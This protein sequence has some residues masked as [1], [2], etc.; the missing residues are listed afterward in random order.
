V[1][2]HPIA[3]NSATLFEDLA[4]LT[5]DVTT[6]RVDDGVQG[7]AFLRVLRKEGTDLRRPIFCHIPMGVSFFEG[8]LRNERERLNDL[9]S[10]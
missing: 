9:L 4:C 7:S 1:D 10:L 8:T 3:D 6:C 5:H 2:L